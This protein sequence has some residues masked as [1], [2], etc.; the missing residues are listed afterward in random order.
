MEEEI[1]SQIEL[2]TYIF[3][4][5]KIDLHAHLNGSIRKTTL[6]E[7]SSDEDKEKLSQ[8]YSKQVTLESAFEI[9]KISSKILKNLEIVGRITREMIEDWNKKNTIY[10]EIR[11]TLKTIGKNTKEEYLTAVLREIEN[12]NKS[13]FCQT[14]LIISLNREYPI[15]DYLETFD[16]YKNFKDKNLKKLIV[17]MDYCGNELSEIH[18]IKDVV[19]IFQKFRNEGLKITIH[20]GES[21]NYQH[22]DFS[23]FKPDRISHTYY[24]NDEE[25]HEVMKNKIP[26][27]ICPTGSYC[28]K[29]LN[30]FHDITFKKY[31][32]QTVKL[33]NGEDYLYDLYCINTDDTML[34]NSDIMQEYF[35][36]ASNFKMTKEQLKNMILKTIDFIFETDEDFKQSI[37]D[38]LR[39]Y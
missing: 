26:I 13:L 9:F 27:E 19:P 5:P 30:S 39:N 21:P 17:G 7:L 18:K 33:D 23:L 12:A 2:N 10:L 1:K 24:Y 28:V 22:F 34:F 29:E 37:R 11:T 36:V 4:I 16:V 14:R 3:S 15:S 38:K 20:S 25:Y 31:H 32:N 6:F 8:L 35:E